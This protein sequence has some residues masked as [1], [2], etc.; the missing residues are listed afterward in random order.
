MDLRCAAAPWVA[1]QDTKS[2]RLSAALHNLLAIF[3]TAVANS[4]KERHVFGC[5]KIRQLGFGRKYPFRFIALLIAF[6]I[7]TLLASQ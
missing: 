3:K 2:D 5:L 6:E 7:G 4:L 1:R